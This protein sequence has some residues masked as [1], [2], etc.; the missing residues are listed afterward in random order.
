MKEI[1]EHIELM[2]LS[3]GDAREPKLPSKR[4]L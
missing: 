2:V 3:R 1:A 4:D